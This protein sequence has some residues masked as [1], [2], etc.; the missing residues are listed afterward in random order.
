VSPFLKGNE[1]ALY[2][3]CSDTAPKK[4]GQWWYWPDPG[5]QKRQERK[6]LD[7]ERRIGREPTLPGGLR[8]M[9]IGLSCFYLPY[10]GQPFFQYSLCWKLKCPSA[11][12]REEGGETGI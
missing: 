6:P 11:A 1:D 5:K 9:N 2:K 10:Q 4:R 12:R 8:I 3:E 7:R